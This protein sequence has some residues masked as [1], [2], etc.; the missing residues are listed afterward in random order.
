MLTATNSGS[1]ASL[2]RAMS[3]NGYA[4]LDLSQDAGVLNLCDAAIE[5]TRFF[6]DAG[7]NRVQD[8]WRQSPAVRALACLPQVLSSLTEVYGSTPFPAQT[9]N[10][11]RGDQDGLH[12]DVIHLTPDPMNLM[13]GA[14]IAL[15]DVHPDAGPPFFYTGSHKEPVLT[16]ID[17]GAPPA[18]P[19]AE[20]YRTYYQNALQRRMEAQGYPCETLLPKKGQVILWAANT[21]HGGS[22]VRDP[23][24]TRRTLIVN[25][26]F[27]GCDYY[28]LLTSRPGMRRRRLPCDI[29]TGRLVWPTGGRPSL[30]TIA[31]EMWG[32]FV[33]RV[34]MF[35]A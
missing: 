11:H 33:N 4:V 30:R 15:E 28:T 26:F 12:V 17:A 7:F 9:L 21:T 18:M 1:P 8:A 34:H 19:P 27:H 31:F 16:L 29:A 23:A 14:M 6:N 10:F 2:S 5:E 25:Y 24:L 32:H 22:L 20:A 13:C 35:H 3:V